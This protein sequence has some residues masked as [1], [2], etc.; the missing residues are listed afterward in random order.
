[1][2]L[3]P[4]SPSH[5]RAKKPPCSVSPTWLYI[6][7]HSDLFRMLHLLKKWYPEDDPITRDQVETLLSL[8]DGTLTETAL[9]GFLIVCSRFV[10]EFGNHRTE[11]LARIFQTDHVEGR[12]ALLSSLEHIN[13]WV[14]GMDVYKQMYPVTIIPPR[15][16]FPLFKIVGIETIESKL[17]RVLDSNSKAYPTNESVKDYIQRTGRLP[18]VPKQRR[19]V[20]RSKPRFHW[21]SYEQ[22]GNPEITRE[23]LQIL[24]GWSDC[25]LRITLLTSKIK[26][27]V[28]VA[29][30]GDRYDPN[31]S[32]LRFYK[33]FY[34]P[35]AQ[36][37]PPLLG[38]GPQIAVDGEPSV[39]TLE[40][41]D[42]LALRW[43]HIWGYPQCSKE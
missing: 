7:A 42:N 25:Q 14:G 31:N 8:L 15:P 16:A 11:E 43:K 6:K 28:Y 27:S 4:G 9:E 40:Q 41:W 1:M 5:L 33:Y 18:A 19:P 38:G 32:K 30:N 26:N 2:V 10:D 36:D 21:C 13:K 22:W 17:Y 20:R 3:A 34:E 39:E 24:R 12:R 23:A 37:H 35:L 29:F